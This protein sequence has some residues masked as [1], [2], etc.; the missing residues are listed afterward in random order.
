MINLIAFY[1]FAMPLALFLAFYMHWGVMGLFAGMGVGP[2]IQ[3]ILYG[4]LVLRTGAQMA[5]QKLL[6]TASAT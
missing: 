5:L 6:L 2:V 4:W 1:V 3:T